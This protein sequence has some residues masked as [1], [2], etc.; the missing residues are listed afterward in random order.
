M[1]E[2]FVTAEVED[3]CECND[4]NLSKEQ[5]KKV[6]NSV[7]NDDNWYDFLI[8]SIQEQLQRIGVE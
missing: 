8:N 2:D 6:V 1:L 4:I 7:V 3:Y 5:M